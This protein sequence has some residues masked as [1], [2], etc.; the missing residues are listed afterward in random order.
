MPTQPGQEPGKP[1]RRVLIVEDD[2]DSREMLRILLELD[3]HDVHEAEDGPAAISAALALQPDVALVDVG[4]PGLDGH[5]VARELR[6]GPAGPRILLVALTGYAEPEDRE[7][8]RKA[9]FDAHVAK[10]ISPEKLAE[11]FRMLEAPRPTP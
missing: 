9:G 8:S 2:K 6:G 7:R 1:C 4:L 5:E 3:G 11:L 10:P